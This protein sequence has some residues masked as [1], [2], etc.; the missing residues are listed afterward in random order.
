MK[1]LLLVS[2]LATTGMAAQA[3]T[4]VLS[5]S[6]DTGGVATNDLNYNQ[7][8]RQAGT[9]APMN[10]TV[11]TNISPV[12]LT[13]AGKLNMKGDGPDWYSVNSDHL[14]TLIGSESFSIKWSTAH[15][16]SSP[17]GNWSMFTVVNPIA[18]NWDVSPMTVNLWS[19]GFIHLDYGTTNDTLGT[20]NLRIDMDPGR[21]GS[22][23]GAAF[24]PDV[25]HDFEIRT[26]ASSASTGTWGFYVDGVNVAAGLPYN[27]ELDEKWLRW[28]AVNA[29]DADWDNL[30]V[31]TIPTPIG[32]EYV[33]FDNF[34]SAD[35]DDMGLL[36]GI[37]QTNGT[38]VS[39]FG[40]HHS[41]YSITNVVGNGKLNQYWPGAFANMD[42]DVSSYIEGKDFELSCKVAVLTPGGE[43][44]SFHLFDNDNAEGG[45]D[46]R[47][48]S[49]LGMHIPGL[50]QPWA[51]ILYY[52]TG[53]AQQTQAIDPNWYAGLAGYDKS[54]EHTFQFVSIA[55]PGGTN[56]CEV[57]IDGVEITDNAASGGN[58]PDSLPYYFNGDQLRI[59]LVGIMPDNNNKNNGA[60][61]DDIYLKVL[62]GNT[63]EDWVA[64]DTNLTPGANDGRT[65]DPDGDL[66]DNLL[67]YA[68]GGD[69]LVDD[70]A[71]ILPMTDYS[72]ADTINY[73]F[74]RRV[75]AASR[76]LTY[77]VL[78]NTNGLQL[79][80]VN[81]GNAFETGTAL[82]TTEI[83]AVT[84]TLDI[85]EINPGFMNL[86]VTEQ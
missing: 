45:G 71:S 30:E 7:A 16:P 52:G 20:T 84:N 25:T 22:A 4:L 62:K 68:L 56:S 23:I 11:N 70:A 31:S 83:E 34:D 3:Q 14:E 36:Y 51:C 17:D 57:F 47:G 67:E 8:T 13:A 79:A 59:G 27:F 28:N 44:T 73:V 85:T 65:D 63:Y 61:Y 78:V 33:F 66:M 6:F 26:V 32:K 43:W 55:G 53:A 76:G 39:S 24:D 5:D 37:R 42:A 21:V 38:I 48:D 77:D 10:Y 58:A 64:D 80:W 72:V 15:A 41:L 82:I 74:R 60:L 9:A 54:Q 86:Q 40:P 50:D 75:D 19:Q 35:H 46:S 81:V 29:T 49:R 12:S 69:P 2:L 1:K 18:G